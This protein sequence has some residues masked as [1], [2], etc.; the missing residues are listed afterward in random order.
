VANI[1]ENKDRRV[2]PNWRSF[3]KTAVL[4]ELDSFDLELKKSTPSII[5]IEDYIEDWRNYKTIPHAGDLLSSAIVNGIT[6]NPQVLEAARFILSNNTT[7]TLSQK[8]LAEKFVVQNETQLTDKLEQI[9]I[10]KF[11]SLVDPKIIWSKIKD[12]K[13]SIAL[14][15]YNPISYIELSRQYSIVGQQEKA[16]RAMRIAL[17]L[18]KENRFILRCAS[19]LFAH[20][21]DIDFAHDILRKSR[22]AGAD[23]WIMSAEIS[24]ATLRGR[25]SRFLKKGMDIVTSNSFSSSSMSELA[26]S[27]GTIELIEGNFKK[28]RQLFKKSL[29]SPNDNTLAQIEWA[30]SKDASLKIDVN[31]YHVKH[32]FEAQAL[33][34]F[35]TNQLTECL[36][37]TFRW[38]LD[39]PFSKR[40][41][42]LGSHIANALLNDQEKSR[43]FLKAGLI[44]H[45]NDPQII[46]NLVYSLALEN[47][48]EEARMFMSKLADNPDGAADITKICL[49]A[50]RG[51]LCFRSGVPDMGR[52]YYLE[53]IEKSKEIKSQYF[54]WLAILNYAR[55]EILVKSEDIGTI[56][57]TVGKIPDNTSAADVNKLKKEVVELYSKSKIVSK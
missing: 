15:P 38:F 23:P 26:S 39:M 14:H 54:N 45:P 21:E 16:L 5:T 51:L 34:Y 32:N 12:I 7:S 40:P 46:N 41:V 6:N 4:G 17:N 10:E 19:R 31:D 3:K 29:I 37:S 2:I 13:A 1:F 55:E 48:L 28:S 18:S 43:D 9:T 52:I 27:M 35:H 11:A 30:S 49:T 33:E 22:L 56:M 57:E 8:T 44:S 50:T 20:Y 24:L 36:N 25:S 53:A 42:M 47:K